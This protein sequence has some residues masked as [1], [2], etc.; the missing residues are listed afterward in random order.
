MQGTVSIMAHSLG[1]VLC[2]EI[3]CNQGPPIAIDDLLLGDE[4]PEEKT[5]EDMNTEECVG[6][7]GCCRISMSI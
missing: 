7:Q 3:L 4:V 2:Y 6:Y 1:S 5:V